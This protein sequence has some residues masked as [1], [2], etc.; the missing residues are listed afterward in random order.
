MSRR[1]CCVGSDS[2]LP[3]VVVSA[4]ADDRLPVR[5]CGC[6]RRTSDVWSWNSV[7]QLRG[8]CP[9]GELGPAVVSP[10]VFEPAGLQ[11]CLVVVGKSEY[12]HGGTVFLPLFGD[13]AGSILVGEVVRRLIVWTH[14]LL[15]RA[16][17]ETSLDSKDV[18]RD[19]CSLV[20]PLLVVS[21]GHVGVAEVPAATVTYGPLILEPSLGA[22]CKVMYCIVASQGLVRSCWRLFCP[23]CF[24]PHSLQ[25]VH[26]SA[27]ERC[28]FWRSTR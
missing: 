7:R 14:G 3:Y 4:T 16:E 19:G 2:T 12:M 20:P 28:Q 15:G 8:S 24:N 17:R 5:G 27:S 1:S 21:S 11:V 9:A 22:F 13:I 6:R 18:R 23:D 26:F 10:A 25:G